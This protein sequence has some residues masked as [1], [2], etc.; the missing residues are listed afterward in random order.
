M[1]KLFFYAATIAALF[2]SCAEEETPLDKIPTGKHSITA[3]FESNQT[4]AYLD[5]NDFCRWELNDKVSVFNHNG[6]HY[7]YTSSKGNVTTTELVTETTPDFAGGNVCAIFPYNSGNTFA[8][9]QFT[10]QIPAEQAYNKEKASLDNAIMVAVSDKEQSLSFK[11]S[12]ALIKFNL[13]A[14]YG[15]EDKF[16]INSIKIT[17]K[18]NNLSGTVTIGEDFTAK[19]SDGGN[20]TITLTGCA[21]AGTMGA[22]TKTFIVAIP[23]GTYAAEDLTFTFD[24]D[25]NIFDYT[26]TLEQEVTIGRNNYIT[27]NCIVPGP[28]MTFANTQFT[29]EAI[30]CHVDLVVAGGFA[31]QES[32]KSAYEIPEDNA[33]IDG[34]NKTYSFET[35][36]DDIYII[37]TFMAKSSGKKGV[38]PGTIWV[39]NLSITGEYRSTCLGTYIN[40]GKEA[41]TSLGFNNGTQFHTILTNVK[42]FDS[43]IIPMTKAGVS[44]ANV[45]ASN[46]VTVYGTA[47]LNDC[48]I[49]GSV[50]AQRALD[51]PDWASIEVFD[52]RCVNGSKT[53][54][55]GGHI[56]KIYGTEQAKIYIQDGAT[57]DYLYTIGVSANSL[58]LV[59]VDNA[60]IKHLVLD[61]SGSYNPNINIA[62]NATIGTL[63]FIGQAGDD[64]YFGTSNIVIAEGATINKVIVDGT[65]MT[66]AQFK[67]TYN[68]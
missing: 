18:S 49:Y 34:E 8:G 45:D 25:Q 35:T 47:E 44:G 36:N 4:R 9:G 20:K 32:V 30:M 38:T 10:S 42:I 13:T 21:E 14:P 6:V 7:A 68:L 11:N 12:C 22:E 2:T 40:G 51:N 50:P 62:A 60:T 53:T 15:F 37:N 26:T 5:N 55:N 27:L 23:A 48:E 61:P 52:M 28:I 1:K 65:E 33:I 31:G 59:K 43:H 3:T 16:K 41:F 56:G 67:E 64:N 63:E 19:I 54:I 39:Q 17:S 58:S 66:F 24:A 57:I 29:D 46:A